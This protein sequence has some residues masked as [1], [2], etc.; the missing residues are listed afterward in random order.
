MVPPSKR[1]HSGTTGVKHME[2]GEGLYSVARRPQVVPHHWY[3][4]STL[5]QPVSASTQIKPPPP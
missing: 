2:P 1:F 3:S 5:T 4:F